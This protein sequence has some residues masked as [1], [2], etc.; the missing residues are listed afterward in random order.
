[1]CL[2]VERVGWNGEALAVRLQAWLVVLVAEFG[3]RS[4]LKAKHVLENFFIVEGEKLQCSCVGSE[5]NG[6]GSAKRYFLI[7]RKN[8]KL[9]V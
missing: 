2:G 9:Q 8:G 6:G 3:G 4:Y 5:R 1:M 7:F